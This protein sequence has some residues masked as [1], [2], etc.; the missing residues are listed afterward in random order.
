LL[1]TPNFYKSMFQNLTP[2]RLKLKPIIPANIR[3]KN[4]PSKVDIKNLENLKEKLNI[5]TCMYTHT[6]Y[7]IN[8]III[9]TS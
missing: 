6:A 9:L 7:Y 8:I 5:I 2:K 4:V 1:H 3:T